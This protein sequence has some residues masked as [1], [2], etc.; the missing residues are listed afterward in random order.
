[1]EFLDISEEEDAQHQAGLQNH[2]APSLQHVVFAAV[3]EV[4]P[5]AGIEE[6]FHLLFE[7]SPRACHYECDKQEVENE[8]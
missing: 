4:R 7:E 6:V 5:F 1:M 8:S 3:E 2:E